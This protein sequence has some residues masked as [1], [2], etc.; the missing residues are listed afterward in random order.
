[1]KSSE[2]H[3]KYVIWLLN[4][5]PDHFGLHQGNNFTVTMQFGS[6][7]DIFQGLH[8]PL[9]WS[10]GFCGG[11]GKRGALLGKDKGLWQRKIVKKTNFDEFIGGEEK[12]ETRE[13]LNSILLYFQNK[14]F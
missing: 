3:V 8:Y 6:P 2:S 14:P 5:S 7:K 4:S 9:T 1:M 10:N 13:W 12:M 11:R